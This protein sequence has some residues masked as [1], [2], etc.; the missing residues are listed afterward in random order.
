MDTMKT[1]KLKPMKSQSLCNHILVHSVIALAC[2]TFLLCFFPSQSDFIKH[3]LF[4]TLP[5]SWYSFVNPTCL[6]IVVNV[7]VG[8]LIAGESKSS[9]SSSSSGS[10]GCDRIYEEY[11]KRKMELNL[12]KEKGVVVVDKPQ[13][14]ERNTNVNAEDVEGEEIFEDV[15]EEEEEEEVV[16][17]DR[18]KEKEEKG[19]GSADDDEDQ[20]GM[21]TEELNRRVEAFIA[22]VNKQRWLEAKSLVCCKA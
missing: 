1:Q 6:F 12:I 22:K 16:D 18:D 15:K 14:E 17:D 8:L 9:S 13:V 3:F 2:S 7:I 11:V 20:N 5:C 19:R 4:T 21:P 10:V